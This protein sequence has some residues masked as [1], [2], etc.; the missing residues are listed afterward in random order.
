MTLLCEY[1]F[2]SRFEVDLEQFPNI[3]RIVE[4]LESVDAFLKAR[5]QE[6]PDRQ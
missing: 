4:E 5:P 6:Q 1:L 3:R 2:F